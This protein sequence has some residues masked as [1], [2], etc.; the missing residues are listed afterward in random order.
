ML[1]MHQQALPFARTKKK[2][3]LYFLNMSLTV[4]L[5][6]KCYMRGVAEM[7]FSSWFV[8]ISTLA[9]VCLVRFGEENGEIIDVI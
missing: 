1:I 5:V 6:S 2:L 7:K 9:P 3:Q 8:Q 4:S